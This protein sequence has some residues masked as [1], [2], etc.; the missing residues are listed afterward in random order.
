MDLNQVTLP[1]IDVARSVAFYRKLG[2]THIVSNLPF[3][4]RF[5]CPIG[6]S[7]FS[8]HQVTAVAPN[9]GVIVYFEC[10]DLDDTFDKLTA[11]GFTFDSPP[12]DQSWL[13]REASLRDP[14][15]NVL[16][17]YHAGENRR[18]PPWRLAPGGTPDAI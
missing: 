18:S 4:A 1:S 16:C 6:G 12:A 13:W 14:D 15:G 11:R 5:E 17:L 2:F 3:Y 8:L 9:T 7:T 10:S